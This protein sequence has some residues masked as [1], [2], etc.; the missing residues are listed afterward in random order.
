[1]KRGLPAKEKNAKDKLLDKK[2]DKHEFSLCSN[3]DEARVVYGEECAIDIRVEESPDSSAL[4]SGGKSEHKEAIKTANEKLDTALNGFL[5][6]S[7]TDYARQ[8]EYAHLERM[9]ELEIEK[10]K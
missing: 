9:Q 6:F 2:L 7:A 5:N 3:K 1:M 10:E 8:K 4:S